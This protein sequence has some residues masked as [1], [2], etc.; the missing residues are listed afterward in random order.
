VYRYQ[1]TEKMGYT[2]GF[3]AC[4]DN[5]TPDD[6]P[7]GCSDIENYTYDFSSQTN[8]LREMGV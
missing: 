5:D 2:P 1:S 4:V 6:M 8:F 7:G 3:L